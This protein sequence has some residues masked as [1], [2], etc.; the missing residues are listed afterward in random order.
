MERR[1]PAP[2]KKGTNALPSRATPANCILCGDNRF[3]VLYRKS[4]WTYLRCK[5]CGLVCLEPK[6]SPEQYRNSY[7]EYL[8]EDA[9][10]IERWSKTMEPVIAS[11]VRL[12]KSRGT[13]QKGKLLDIGSGY[14]FFLRAMQLEGWE[15]E[16][17][18]IS[19][20]GGNF[21]ESTWGIKVHSSPLEE[22]DL[23]KEDYDVVTLFYVIEHVPDPAGLIRRIKGILKPEGLLLLRWPHTTPLVRM[24][25]PFSRY[26]DLYHTPYHLYDFS[27]NTIEKLMK[28]C[29]FSRIETLIG[30]HTRPFK[31]PVRLVSETAGHLGEVLYRVSRG[32]FL[33]PGLSK[34]TLARKKAG[35]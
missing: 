18:E 16:G 6:P 31:R 21:A 9:L 13:A 3:R 11:S 24:M 30:G 2:E 25:G 26:L 7:D 5:G 14:G 22:L 10:E 1:E 32:R 17:V 8:P 35:A 34:T 19:R 33:M 20:T 4:R 12:I 27:P 23:A 29:G 15:V 28:L